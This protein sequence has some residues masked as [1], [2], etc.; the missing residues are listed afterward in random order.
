[1]DNSLP[2]ID[3]ERYRRFLDTGMKTG[4]VKSHWER[5]KKTTF[6]LFNVLIDGDLKELVAVL[7]HFPDYIPLVCE[8][9]RY[10]YN[11]SETPADPFA[12]STLLW[13]GEEYQ[14]NRFARNVLVKLP[15]RFQNAGEIREYLDAMEASKEELHPIIRFHICH[16]VRNWM[17]REG[18]HKLQ[19]I[20][21]DKK[22]A[23]LEP[24]ED[25][26]L[27]SPDKDDGAEIPYLA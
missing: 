27:R 26:D 11:Y 5:T 8:H 14:T 2:E 23:S 1:M 19:R 7:K 16:K 21:L 6:T 17:D 4:D 10:S 9:F 24:E 12:A 13:M 3:M 15:L 18:L 25:I 22:L 20:A